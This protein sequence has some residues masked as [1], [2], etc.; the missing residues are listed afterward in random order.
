MPKKQSKKKQIFIN[1]DFKNNI[2]KKYKKN[3]FQRWFINQN[4]GNKK[5]HINLNLFLKL[6][7]YLTHEYEI[8]YQFRKTDKTDY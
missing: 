3:N 6:P 8:A 5:N 7:G 2:N 4:D 1:L